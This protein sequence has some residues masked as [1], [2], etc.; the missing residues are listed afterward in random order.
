MY[1]NITIFHKYVQILLSI[2]NNKSKK[3]KTKNY[4]TYLGEINPEW[5]KLQYILVKILKRNLKKKYLKSPDTK[6]TSLT[7]EKNID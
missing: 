7:I 1:Q 2:K 3:M 6:T 5:T 4:I